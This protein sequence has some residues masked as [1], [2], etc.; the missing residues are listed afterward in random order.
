MFYWHE[1]ESYSKAVDGWPLKVRAH[2]PTNRLVT[3]RED[4]QK[5]MWA[6]TQEMKT[7]SVY[8]SLMCCANSVVKMKVVRVWTVK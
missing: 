1:T 8:V 2:T 6:Y 5:M 3:Y 7:A 4:V